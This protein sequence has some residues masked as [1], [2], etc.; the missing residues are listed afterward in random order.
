MLVWEIMD[1]RLP[2]GAQSYTKRAL[3][4]GGWLVFTEGQAYGREGLRSGG[5]T[6][7]PDPEHQWERAS[8]PVPPPP[9]RVSKYTRH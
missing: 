2:T 3:V 1:S 8:A 5:L 6:F 9:A 4:P 7:Y